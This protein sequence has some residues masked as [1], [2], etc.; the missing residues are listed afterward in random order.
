MECDQGFV[1]R[2]VSSVKIFDERSVDHQS[3]IYMVIGNSS[4]RNPFL[5][6]KR[7]R[8]ASIDRES[9]LIDEDEVYLF[10]GSDR[11]ENILHDRFTLARSFSRAR[12]DSKRETNDKTW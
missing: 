9:S 2:L 6:R 8:V 11:D 12:D 1:G 3:S 5:N 4:S 7:R 10:N